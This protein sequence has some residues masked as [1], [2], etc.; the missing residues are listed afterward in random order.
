MDEAEEKV[1][2]YYKDRKV[3]IIKDQDQDTTDFEKA[4][5]YTEKSGIKSV[6]ALG[7][8]GGRMDHTLNSMHI[9]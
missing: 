2:N 1:L 9:S 5:N 8:F 3:E 6:I 4:M 7:V